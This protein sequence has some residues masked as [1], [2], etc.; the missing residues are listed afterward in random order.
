M[1]GSI[2]ADNPDGYEADLA[3][4]HHA[5][6]RWGEASTDLGHTVSTISSLNLDDAQFSI[7]GSETGLIAG[8]AALHDRMTQL[9]GEGKNNLSQLQDTLIKVA[10]IY[11][12]DD[13][14]AANEMNRIDGGG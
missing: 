10:A 7:L 12:E 13:A 9:L 14:Y 6:K 5:A 4:M 3:A 2:P 8:Y 1:T 11:A